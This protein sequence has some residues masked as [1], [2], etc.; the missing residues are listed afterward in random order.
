MFRRP[1]LSLLL[2]AALGYFSATAAPVFAHLGDEPPI[3]TAR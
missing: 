2:A 3:V 1:W